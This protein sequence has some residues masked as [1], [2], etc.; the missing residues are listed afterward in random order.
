MCRDRARKAKA[1]LELEL[2]WGMWRAARR[3]SIS[4]LAPNE[5][6]R[7][8]GPLLSGAGKLVT[9]DREK[10]K[11]PS[12]ALPH[13]FF[14]VLVGFSHVPPRSSLLW[15]ESMWSKVSSLEQEVGMHGLQRS[16]PTCVFLWFRRKPKDKLYIRWKTMVGTIVLIVTRTQI[17][18]N[19]VV[20]SIYSIFYS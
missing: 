12:I 19:S 9:N 11:V 13:C 6:E 20:K 3:A 8:V 17:Y 7:N 4:T 10:A 2:Q 14:F 18:F 1:L 5:G 16:P 15:A